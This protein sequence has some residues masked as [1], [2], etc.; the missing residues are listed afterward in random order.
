M[1]EIDGPY[2]Q[3]AAS[4]MGETYTMASESHQS[5]GAD[6]VPASRRQG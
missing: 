1:E 6:T 5:G 3:E 2:P 4:L